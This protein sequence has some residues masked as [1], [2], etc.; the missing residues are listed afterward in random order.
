MNYIISEEVTAP[1]DRWE[2]I[3]ILLDCG[4]GECAYALGY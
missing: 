3:D 2:L 1:K 4:P